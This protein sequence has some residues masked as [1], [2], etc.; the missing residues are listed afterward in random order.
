MVLLKY[1]IIKVF[2][3]KI[4]FICLLFFFI[5]QGNKAKN[6]NVTEF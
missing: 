4:D 6:T 1:F 3:N 5:K 2:Y